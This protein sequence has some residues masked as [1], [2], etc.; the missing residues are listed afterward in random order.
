MTEKYTLPAAQILRS[1]REGGGGGGMV[2][3]KM[4]E[5][6]K[7]EEVKEKKRGGKGGK[8]GALFA[9]IPLPLGWT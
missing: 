1:G 6:V 7:A 3:E 5:G 4:D 9:A 8:V 2:K